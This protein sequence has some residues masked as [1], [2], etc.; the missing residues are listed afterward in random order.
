MGDQ[1]NLDIFLR[2]KNE[3]DQAFQKATG[4]VDGL[5][6]SATDLTQSLKNATQGWADISGAL[7]VAG[8][9]YDKVLAAYDKMMTKT[10]E[11][12]A[13]VEDMG[14]LIGENA[15]NASGLIVAAETIGIQQ[16]TLAQAM[17]MAISK[18]I[19]PNIE[20]L[21]S[22]ADEYVAIEDPL[23]RSA[24]LMEN[25]GRKAG[26]EMAELLAQGSD[27]L[28]KFMDAAEKTGKVID[29]K[30]IASLERY[31][32]M[33]KKLELQ[34]DGLTVKMG[35]ELVPV[36]SV[37]VDTMMR[38]ADAVEENNLRWTNIVPVL[39]GAVQAYLSIRNAILSIREQT[40]LLNDTPPTPPITGLTATS[41]WQANQGNVST[42]PGRAAG[43]PMWAGISRPVGE[44]GVEWFTPDRGGTISDQPA[45]GAGVSIGQVTIQI[46]SSEPRAVRREVE[47][48]IRD[49]QAVGRL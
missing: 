18:G 35:T 20:G 11:W 10:L 47:Q 36:L 23:D 8:G 34:T 42:P 33:T 15:E 12:G 13:T 32:I 28:A 45:G 1:E 49:L 3:T 16:Q 29:E 7:S 48:A 5:K 17:E 22:L 9:M 4:N 19:R 38:N 39:G 40:E 46:L 21:K 41:L 44:N 6:G 30:T 25:F 31:E 24:F 2:A 26:P 14:R 37:M 43:G 27:G